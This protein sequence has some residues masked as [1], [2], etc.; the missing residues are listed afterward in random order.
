M[1]KTNQLIAGFI[2]MAGFTACNSDSTTTTTTDST[3]V[4]SSD[5]GNAMNNS[6]PMENTSTDTSPASKMP[7]SKGD[8]MFVMKAAVGGMLEVE[9][10]K[11]AQQNGMNDRVKGFGSMLIADHSKANSELMSLVSGR[12]ITLPTALPADKQKHIDD[13]MKMQGKAFDKHFVSMMSTDHKKDIAEFEKQANSGDDAEL[14][15]FAAKTLPTLKMHLDSVQ[16]L[17]KIKM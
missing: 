4:S 12:G 7:L 10:G 11:A 5:S 14:K 13:M 17:A 9:S 8:S 15:A 2:L 6:M 3:S 16:A 1:K